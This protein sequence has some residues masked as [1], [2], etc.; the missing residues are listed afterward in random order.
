MTDQELID[1]TREFVD[2]LG[3]VD[4]ARMCSVVCAPLAGFL[5]FSGVDARIEWVE[6]ELGRDDFE[7][8]CVISLADGRILDPTAGQYPDM[9]PIYLGEAPEHYWRCV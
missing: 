7:D 4:P 1:L 9:P 3:V 8:H 5:S 2:G 6:V